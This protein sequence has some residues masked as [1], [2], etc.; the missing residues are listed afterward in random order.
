MWPVVF[1]LHNDVRWRRCGTR[2][3]IIGIG[4]HAFRAYKP[5]SEIDKALESAV[6]EFFLLV[7]HVHGME[8]A[9]DFVFVNRDNGK[10][11]ERLQANSIR[12][13]RAVIRRRRGNHAAHRDF[14]IVILMNLKAI[15]AH[16]FID[17]IANGSSRAIGI[18]LHTLQIFKLQ[19]ATECKRALLAYRDDE[20]MGNYGFETK[21]RLAFLLGGENDVIFIVL[22][23]FN[24]IER[25]TLRYAELYRFTEVVVVGA[26]KRRQIIAR[27]SV[28]RTY[29]QLARE[30]T[31]VLMHNRN[32]L[33]KLAQR[34][35]HIGRELFAIAR[36]LH[37]A[38]L[39]LKQRNAEFLLKRT[40]SV[41]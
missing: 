28:Q 27:D 22:Q 6:L 17:L 30:L 9:R 4:K 18:H 2:I 36:K 33:I 1:V 13:Q 14:V 8:L 41:R 7:H 29:G 19:H 10:V 11:V 15:T 5:S 37:V 35:V 20:L 39:A 34:I 40:N 31:R 3:L 26:N 25:E 24:K 12:E 38:P 21:A 32:A 16:K 23:A